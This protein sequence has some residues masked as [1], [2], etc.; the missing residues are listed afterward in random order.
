M[1]I[2]KN[3]KMIF[4]NK[5]NSSISNFPDFNFDNLLGF[6]I[7]ILSV[8][9]GLKY[10]NFTVC[11]SLIVLFC[12][13]IR[14]NKKNYIL[15]SID[16]NISAGKSTFINYIK[17]KTKDNDR[18]YVIDEPVDKW[19]SILDSSGKSILQAFYEDQKTMSFTFQI[20]ALLTRYE[21]LVKMLNDVSTLYSDFNKPMVVFIERTIYSDY[22]I[23]AKMLYEDKLIS[24]FEFKTYL[25]WFD[26]FSIEFKLDKTI[27]LKVSPEICYERT[28]IR[29]RNGEETISLEYLK[30]CH[31]KHEEF[32][33]NVLINYECIT[34]DNECNFNS[35]K[36]KENI[37]ELLNSIY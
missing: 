18:V 7:F 35:D 10:F 6:S 37:D 34:I 27:Y 30:R 16:A 29:N 12:F 33:N 8:I 15:I 21:S 4:N 31:D 25:M 23:F 19:T 13:I 14:Q 24:E 32:Y 20:C 3:S 2:I 5:L 11:L 17:E 28:K 36:Y 22:H 9:Y 26:R 1:S